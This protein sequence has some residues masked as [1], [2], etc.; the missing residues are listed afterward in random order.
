[1]IYFHK[2][3][4]EVAKMKQ[5]HQSKVFLPELPQPTDSELL[6]EVNQQ[7]PDAKPFKKDGGKGLFFMTNVNQYLT[8]KK[9]KDKEG[10]REQ[11]DRISKA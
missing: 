3:Y 2:K 1:M 10:A 4:L 7:Y 9:R 6:N 8:L 5:Q 11:T